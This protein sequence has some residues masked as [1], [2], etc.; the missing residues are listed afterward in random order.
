MAGLIP[1]GVAINPS[2]QEWEDGIGQTENTTVKEINDA[3]RRI[4]GES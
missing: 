1:S 4:S 3:K 2:E